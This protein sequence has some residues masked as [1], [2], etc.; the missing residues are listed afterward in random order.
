VRFNAGLVEELRGEFAFEG[1]DLATEISFLCLK[2]EHASSDRAQSEHAPT[3]LGIASPFGSSGCQAA[4]QWSLRQ[5]PQLA[6]QRLRGRDQQVAQ[7]GKSRALRVDSSFPCR[8]Q[9]LQCLTIAAGPRRR[10]PLLS[11]HAP[12]GPD[13]IE[14]IGLAA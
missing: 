8:H 13:R 5:Q 1:F 2:L 7:L 11:E 14:R 12:G 10:R 4:Q 9:R 3:Q 6:A